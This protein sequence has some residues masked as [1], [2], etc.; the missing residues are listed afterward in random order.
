MPLFQ[1]VLVII[2]AGV[3][4]WLIDYIPMKEPYK[5]IAQGLIV[6]AIVFWL[7]SIFIPGLYNLPIGHR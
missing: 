4:A 1:V 2:V 6:V 5:R 7:V 3:V